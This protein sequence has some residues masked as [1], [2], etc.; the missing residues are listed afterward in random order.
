ML[1]CSQAVCLPPLQ[2][3]FHAR[4]I[5]P[6]CQLQV[7]SRLYDSEGEVRLAPDAELAAGGAGL[8][9]SSS[10]FLGRNVVMAGEVVALIEGVASAEA[11]CQ[12]C[13]LLQT[14][15]VA[16]CNVWNY[17]N[18]PGGCRCVLCQAAPPA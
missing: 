11:C 6:P 18:A 3:A 5:V 13:R 12:E 9:N 4:R 7:A 17:C 8:A 16:S 10:C 14:S 1:A 2:H 15:G